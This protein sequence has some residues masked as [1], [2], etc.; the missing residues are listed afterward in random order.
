MSFRLIS[1]N[2]FVLILCVICTITPQF[3]GLTLSEQTFEIITLLLKKNYLLNCILF[4]SFWWFSIILNLVHLG[5]LE[6]WLMDDGKPYMY[7]HNIESS[8]VLVLLLF[9]TDSHKWQSFDKVPFQLSLTNTWFNSIIHIMPQIFP[10]K[11]A[12]KE[13]S[14]SCVYKQNMR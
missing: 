1:E 7:V 12:V 2:T 11:V 4:F 13:K 5:V 8:I 3:K 9:N 6:W 14:H 10:S